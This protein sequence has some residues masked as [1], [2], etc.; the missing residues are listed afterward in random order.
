[1]ATFL[2]EKYAGV[3]FD[4]VVMLGI[5]GMPF[6]LEHREMFAPGV[7]VVFSD[8]T[9]ATY[10]A[11][12]LPPDVTAVINEYD[13]EKTLELAERLQPDARRLVVIAGNDS[14]DRRWRETVRK[15]IEVRN[16]KLETTYRSDLS[17][18]ALLADVSRLPRDTIVMFL[19]FYADSE[20]KRL[21]PRDVAAA[22]AKASAAPVYGLFETYLGSGIVGGYID[23][24]QSIGTTTADIALE[25]LSGKA[26]AT[27]PPHPNPDPE[28]PSR[29]EGDGAVGPAAKQSSAS[30]HCLVQR[31]HPLGPTSQSRAGVDIRHRTTG[32]IR[33]SLAGSTAQKTGSRGLARGK[34]KIE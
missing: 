26:V 30:Q 7:P 8:V 29:R 27:L 13:P 21:I 6:L 15:A 28:F 20:N 25:I 16:P 31:A 24:F 23:S 33:D 4:A 18:D 3:H 5:T 9:R 2:H 19:T 22:V 14:L 17:Y 11:M 12:H 32:R 10:E 1:M 34:A